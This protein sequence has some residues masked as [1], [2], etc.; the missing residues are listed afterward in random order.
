MSVLNMQAAGR[1][2]VSPPLSFTAVFRARLMAR[3]LE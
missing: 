2:T 3:T 1:Y